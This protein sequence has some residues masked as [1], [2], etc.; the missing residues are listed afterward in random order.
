MCDHP[1]DTTPSVT[2]LPIVR[3]IGSQLKRGGQSSGAEQQLASHEVI[4]R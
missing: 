1:P 2:D 4:S 3:T